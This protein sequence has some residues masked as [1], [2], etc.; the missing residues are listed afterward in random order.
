MNQ[1]N[2]LKTRGGRVPGKGR[3]AR[4]YMKDNV[5]KCEFEE[6]SQDLSKQQ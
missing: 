5:K 4:K 1:E 6:H 3:T 2:I